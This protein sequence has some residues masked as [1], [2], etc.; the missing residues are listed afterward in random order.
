MQ[1]PTLK[2][3]LGCNGRLIDDFVNID[4]EPCEGSVQVDVR[5][6]LPYDDNAVD[7]INC[8]HFLEHLNIYEA[9]NILKECYRVLKPNSGIRVTCPD[10]HFLIG[11]LLNGNL[12]KYA[13]IQ[14]P[15][16]SVVTSQML[17]FS[18]LAL[19]NLS[20]DCSREHYTGH[21]LLLDFE[22]IR[23]LLE[24]VGFKEIR[25]MEHDERLD[26]AVGKGYSVSLEA[27]K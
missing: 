22:A 12:S 16:Y 18:L 4:I 17:K 8:S 13:L 20:V 26:A 25:E 15:A 5:R 6:G 3:N 24:R 1:K 27:S 11:E 14:P 19:G 7:F 23:E 10:I 21:Q 9:I 2:L